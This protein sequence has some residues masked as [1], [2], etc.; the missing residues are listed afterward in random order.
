[1]NA[2][3]LPIDQFILTLAQDILPAADLCPGAKLAR[4][5]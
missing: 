3:R 4:P 5:A 2:V 1:L